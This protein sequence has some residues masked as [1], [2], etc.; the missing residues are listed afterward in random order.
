MT[1]ITVTVE[2]A[3]TATPCMANATPALRMD[4]DPTVEWANGQAWAWTYPERAT[5][6][7]DRKSVV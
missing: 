2:Q 5:V 1:T 6:I 7:V 4:G 3:R